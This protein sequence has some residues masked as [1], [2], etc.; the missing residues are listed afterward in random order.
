[1]DNAAPP[2]PKTSIVAATTTF[3]VLLKST[4]LLINIS[5]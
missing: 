3:L 1:M 5:E 2:N 4:W